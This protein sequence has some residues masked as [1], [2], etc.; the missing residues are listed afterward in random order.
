MRKSGDFEYGGSQK[1]AGNFGGFFDDLLDTAGSTIQNTINQA[2]DQLPDLVSNLINPQTGQ[3]YPAGTAPTPIVA[4]AP[5]VIV[6]PSA[7]DQT[8]SKIG[9]TR[10]QLYIG[11]GALSGLILLLAFLPKKRRQQPPV[12]VV[13]GGGQAAPQTAPVAQNPKHKRRKIKKS[14]RK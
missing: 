10:K 12:I 3:P 1:A 7:L 9:I 8:L 4:P 13:S 5:Q 11:V 14:G 2:A 6:R